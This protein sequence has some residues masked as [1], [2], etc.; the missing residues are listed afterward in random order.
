MRVSSIQTGCFADALVSYAPGLT[1][2]GQ[3]VPVGRNDPSKAVS[4]PQDADGDN[5]VSLG[6]GGQITLEFLPSAFNGP[7]A[8]VQVVE[9]SFGSPG[10]AAYPERVAVFASQNGVDFVYLGQGC[11]SEPLAFDLGPLNWA[12]YVRLVDVSNT[13]DFPAAADGFDVDGVRC[14]NGRTSD[15]TPQELNGCRANEVVDYQ[16][17]TRKNGRPIPVNRNDP[18]RA[19]GDP[20]ENDTFNFVS[21]GIGPGGEQ[22]G[23]LTLGFA[24]TIFDGPGPDLRVVETSFRN[25]V[26]DAYPERA[27]VYVSAEPTGPYVLLGETCLDGNFDLAAAGVP[28]ANYVKLVDVSDRTRFSGQADGYDVDAVVCLRGGINARSVGA[29]KRFNLAPDEV[30]E[31]RAGL[32]P[33]PARLQATMTVEAPARAV[34]SYRVYNAVG[35]QMAADELTLPATG[36][37]QVTLPVGEWPT[38][39]YLI[40]LYDD[41]G[42]EQTLKLIRQ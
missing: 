30:S 40:R 17:A 31:L 5:F 36:I 22:G 14:L 8:D 12:R 24:V 10:C 33:N 38:G 9:T 35:I 32:F 3:P 15:D 21:L 25:P 11:Q 37:E 16:P 7:G 26:C 18:N 28:F 2:G 39:V 29:S 6:F 41:N 42:E 19:L 34:V 23:S 4:A 1:K 27:E 13:A 20:Q